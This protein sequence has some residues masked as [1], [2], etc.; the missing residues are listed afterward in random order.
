MEY[1]IVILAIVAGCTGIAGA[2]IPALPGPPLSFAGL[3]LLLLCDNNGIGTV[4]IVTAGLM[5]VVITILDYVAPLWLTKK[6]GGTKY[7]MWGA[8]IGMIAGMFT[9]PLG[10]VVCPFV[11]AFIGELMAKAPTGKA[12]KTAFISFAAFMLTTGIKFVY[13]TSILIIIIV[14]GWKLLFTR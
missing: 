11:G 8:A 10:I 13:C 14:E 9:G 7:G 4:P 12:L 3:L 5:A 1:I 6:K 2:L